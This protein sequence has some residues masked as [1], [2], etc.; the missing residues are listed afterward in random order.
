MTEQQKLTRNETLVLSVLSDA[1]S[2]R[3]AY[4]ILD[5]LRP[6]G[7]RA[8]LQVYRALEKLTQ[9]GLVHRLESLNAFVACCQPHDHHRHEGGVTAFAICDGCGSVDEFHDHAIE[10]RLSAWQSKA[11]FKPTKTT[12]EIRGRCSRCAA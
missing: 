4:D 5:S 12:I 2:P 3:S 10:D 9:A 8:P 6:E 7:F 11:Q 1:Q